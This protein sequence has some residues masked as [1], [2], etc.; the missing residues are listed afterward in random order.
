MVAMATKAKQAIFSRPQG[1]TS[2]A[3]NNGPNEP[4]K[5]PPTWNTDWAKP[6]LPPEAK[7][8]IREASGWRTDDPTPIMKTAN[9]TQ[10]RL[11]AKANCTIPTKVNV[12]PAGNDQAKGCLSKKRP[13]TG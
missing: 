2:S 6:R 7:D 3:T 11:G 9:S 8:V 10:W 5:L 1:A 4:P 12:M 13:A